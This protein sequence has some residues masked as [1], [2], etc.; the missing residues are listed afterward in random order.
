MFGSLGIWAIGAHS[1]RAPISR[2]WRKKHGRTANSLAFVNAFVLRSAVYY[3]LVP[4]TS[5]DETRSVGSLKIPRVAAS[6]FT[7]MSPAFSD[8]APSVAG[9]EVR[10]VLGRGGMGVVYE[11]LEYRFDRRVALKVS[12]SSLVGSEHD[13][14]QEARIA[15]QVDDPGFVHVYDFGF[16]LDRKPYFAMEYVEGHDLAVH[17]RE[18]PMSSAR[19]L[20]IVLDIARAAAAAHERGIVHRDLKPRNVMIDASERAR[21][22][23]F[24]VA[25]HQTDTDEAEIAGSLPYMAPEQML[26]KPFGPPADVYAIGL[27]LFEMLTGRRPFLADNPATMVF[28]STQE[29]APRVSTLVPAV[30]ADLDAIVARCLEKEP[31]KRF[32]SGRELLDVLLAVSEGKPLPRMVEP[33]APTRSPSATNNAPDTSAATRHF[34]RAWTLKSSVERLWPHVS[35][36]DRL[37]RAAG[38]A[39]VKAHGIPSAENGLSRQGS[40]QALG[41]NIEWQEFPFEWIRERDH[42][43][44]RVYSSGPLKALWNHVALLPRADGGTDLVHTIS[45]VPRGVLGELAVLFEI[46]QRTMRGLDR[47]YQRIDEILLEGTDA[48]PF[49]EGHDPDRDQVAFVDGH[50]A[51]LGTLGFDKVL[52]QRLRNHLL[53]SPSPTI[54]RLRPRLLA[55]EWTADPSTTMDMFM[56]ARNLGLVRHAWDIVCPGCRVPHECVAELAQVTRNGE[57]TGCGVKFELDLSESVELIFRPAPPVRVT[58]LAMYCMGS[59]AAR[60]HIVA[61]QVLAPGETRQVHIPLTRGTFDFCSSSSSGRSPVVVSASAFSEELE[62]IVRDGNAAQERPRGT[63]MT[64]PAVVRAGACVLT[65]RNEGSEP[66]AMRLE[67]PRGDSVAVRASEALLHP[68]FELAASKEHIAHNEY[69]SVSEQSYLCLEV[70]NVSELL[71]KEGDPA[72]FATIERIEAA[73]RLMVSRHNGTLFGRAFT[74]GLLVAGFSTPT[75]ALGAA[76]H[77]FRTLPEPMRA[78]LHTGSALAYTRG[79]HIEYFGRTIQEGIHILREV[80]SRCLG[81]APSLLAKREPLMFLAKESLTMRVTMT[82]NA[83]ASRLGVVTMP[84]AIPTRE[85]R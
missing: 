81:L 49:E 23:D 4:M 76:I 64:R 45:L 42:R 44:H 47:V 13:L 50:I 36:T 6:P 51:S 71:L 77:C 79:D 70:A 66:V 34:R 1:V 21:V 33:M 25:I 67:V 83:P 17:L 28:Q 69:L 29:P 31:E 10:G 15:A 48:D 63:V 20:R 41:M 35:N 46:G 39:E 19:A 52:T 80:D 57:C 72:T 84:V 22:L 60:S 30:H 2:A 53:F 26:K 59:P 43:V 40:L 11:A 8:S 14:F 65:L 9:Y 7:S 5:D 18:G 61:Q 78:S 68:A 85:D 38:L 16:T 82:K 58:E 24:G 75:A 3:T 73:F 56:A 55:D 27:I 62:L 74:A 37:N 32:R 54:A 12:L